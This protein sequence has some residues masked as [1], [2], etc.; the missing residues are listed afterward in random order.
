MPTDLAGDTLT[1]TPLDTAAGVLHLGTSIAAAVAA[2][3]PDPE[4][5]RAR[6]LAR[7]DQAKANK[8]AKLVADIDEAADE[9]AAGNVRPKRRRHLESRILRKFSILHRDGYDVADVQSLRAQADALT[10]PAS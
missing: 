6:G 2:F 10:A 7:V 1:A 4:V 8:V 9:I 5:K 3:A